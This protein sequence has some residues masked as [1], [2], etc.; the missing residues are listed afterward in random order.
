MSIIRHDKL[1]I[2][3]YGAINKLVIIFIYF[4]QIP[5]IIDFNLIDIC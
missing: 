4:Y 5:S 2:T 1:N 3:G